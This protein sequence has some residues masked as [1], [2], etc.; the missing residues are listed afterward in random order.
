VVP[1]GNINQFFGGLEP[2]ALHQRD[3]LIE[4]LD[5]GPDPVEL[6]A[7]LSARFAPPTLTNTEGDPL[8]ICEA[9]VQVGDPAR[10][11]SALDNTCD[12]VDGDE[13]PQWF[14]HFTTQGMQR[15]RA[16]RPSTAT[17][18]GWKPTARSGWTACW[19]RWRTSTPR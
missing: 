7:Y 4:L 6:V 10:I 17:R 5:S 9:T 18:C 19:P 1:A 13:Q 2:V 8:A 3:Q 14:E 15:I 16:A 11:E 12:R